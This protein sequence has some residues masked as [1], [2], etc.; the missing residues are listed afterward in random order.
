MTN[1]PIR[2]PDA[3]IREQKRFFVVVSQSV[4]VRG[5]T[6]RHILIVDNHPASLHLLRSLDL[7]A[8]RRSKLVYAVLAVVLVLTTGLGMF[9]PLL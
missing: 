2:L 1:P 3:T 4:T 5:K 7:T 6:I 9:W 8:R